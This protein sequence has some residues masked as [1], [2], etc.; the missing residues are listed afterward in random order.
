MDDATQTGPA[1]AADTAD[2]ATNAATTGTTAGTASGLPSPD[3]VVA[4]VS[5]GEPRRRR[6]R[7]R[8]QRPGDLTP[9]WT[10]ALGCAWLLAVVALVGVW[11]SSRTTGLST[12]WLG[13]EARP[14]SPFVTALPFVTPLVA[15]LAAF[16]GVRRAP[17]YGVVA[18]VVTAAIGLGE[19]GRVTAYGIVEL[20]IAG[21]T[22]VVSVASFAGMYRH[23]D[24][25]AT[26]PA[27][28][29]GAHPER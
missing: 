14:A 15:T 20:V 24:A 17:W 26:V 8:R 29:D 27:P 7:P 5:T 3:D 18:S 1:P 21:A 16:W 11:V 13:P 23:P 10:T 12:W 9:G 2:A 19:L 22:L 4:A 25:T 28:G 6:R